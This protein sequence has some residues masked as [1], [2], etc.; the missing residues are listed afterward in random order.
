MKRNLFGAAVALL[1]A[2]TVVVLAGRPARA[3]NPAPPH[4]AT[5]I[6][7]VE[8]T[9]AH[10]YVGI[11]FPDYFDQLYCTPSDPISGAGT[12]V[13]VTIRYANNGFG[14]LRHA[15][16][17]VWALRNGLVVPAAREAVQFACAGIAH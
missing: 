2:L 17:R 13:G 11:E 1:G 12:I 16:A 8:T 3:T 14:D 15:A 10:G 9:D 6:Y 7:I 4:V 5:S